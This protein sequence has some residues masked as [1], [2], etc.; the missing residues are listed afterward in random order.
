M[1][2]FDTG[3]SAAASRRLLLLLWAATAVVML[4]VAWPLIGPM[5]F[6][7]PDD[8]LRLVQVRDLIAGQSW[9]DVTQYR[10]NPPHGVPMHWSR[11]VDAPLALA[12][13]ALKPM[14]GTG[15]AERVTL[16]TV[17]LLYLLVLFMAVY[18]LSRRLS[19][20]RGTALLAAA[21]LATS[22]SILIQFAPMR[23]DHHG[24][25]ILCGAIAMVALTSTYRKDG[26]MGI[27]AGAAFACWMQISIEGLPYAIVAGAI[28]ALRF[29]WQADRWPDFV[30][31]LTTLTGLSALLLFGTHYPSAAIIP[32]C[33]VMSPSYLT[34]L[35]AATVAL[36][37]TSRR[38]PRRT[39]AERL[40][41][42]AFAG[43]AGAV[44]F[45]VLAP[46]QCLAGP[47]AG[48][49]P[50]V[51]QY[52]Y[53]GVLEGLPITLQKPEIQIIIVLPALLGLVG[54]TI[55]MRRAMRVDQELAWASLIVMQLAAFA[56]ALDVMRAMAFAHLVA[57]PGNA[58]LLAT[59][60][61]A[62]Q[63]LKRLPLRVALTSATAVLTPFGA[64]A[65]TA[66]VVAQDN[67]A[68]EPAKVPDR[69]TCTTY[70]TLR[71]LDALPT[72]ILFSPLDIGAH[73]LAY[74]HHSVVGTGHH[75]N[76]E[77]MKA[78]IH[79]LLA[80]PDQARQIIAAT[81]ARYVVY[82]DGENEIGRYAKARP[83]G[84]MAQLMAGHRPDWLVPV[85]MRPGE[86]VHVLRFIAPPARGGV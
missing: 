77:G 86:S 6:R 27:I 52:W 45:L 54:S 48:L 2:R 60:M 69:Y 63:R 85:P 39:P 49:D 51:R 33:D 76:V 67:S 79:G 80:P 31:Y 11:L 58:V 41:P 57:L 20:G 18:L 66:A 16:V 30:R 29:L 32:W 37:V 64:A 28:L 23:I 55:A 17:P 35:A 5:N 83:N 22:I 34:P 25:Q 74:T 19:L 26:R 15:L 10:L 24:P 12:L 4:V 73:L 7:D 53:Y 82:C 50:L 43:I 14:L 61:T 59:L 21:L 70:D 40:M 1:S 68:G 8:A 46:S 9:F 3:L 56:I 36:I 81:G 42:L 72:T 65:A 47:F 38:M 44:T 78:V 84:L 62:A 13:L 71:G 75:R